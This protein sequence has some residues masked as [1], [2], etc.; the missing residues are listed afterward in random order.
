[1]DLI[2]QQQGLPRRPI[3]HEPC[4][5]GRGPGDGSARSHAREL[6]AS[7]RLSKSL[8]EGYR[9]IVKKSG[10]QA[11]IASAGVKRRVDALPQ[12]DSELPRLDQVRCRSLAPLLVC[13]GQPGVLAQ[14]IGG[15]QW[16]I[17][18]QHT[19][20]DMISTSQFLR[21]RAGAGKRSRSEASRLSARWS[22]VHFSKLVR[23]ERHFE[24]GPPLR[25]QRLCHKKR[26]T[27]EGSGR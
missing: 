20:A 18:V 11:Y 12:G 16:T 23:R 7:R 2:S 10:L 5:N 1:M 3:Q 24:R 21:N 4:G 15:R 22:L 6:C 17:S 9:A 19:E 26:R 14:P 8:T 27:C 25:R 13:H